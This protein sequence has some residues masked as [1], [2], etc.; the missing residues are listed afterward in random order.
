[1]PITTSWRVSNTGCKETQPATEK[2]ELQRSSWEGRG[3]GEKNYS[4]HPPHFLPVPTY[5][6]CFALVAL[7]D[8]LKATINT[9][10]VICLFG[11]HQGSPQETPTI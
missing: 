5:C 3:R 7:H 10:G 11:V 2:P 6:H 1:M 4:K 8:G 9:E